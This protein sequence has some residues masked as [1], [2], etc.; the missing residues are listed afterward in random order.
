MREEM[1]DRYRNARPT[2]LEAYIEREPKIQEA[3]KLLNR[4]LS[5][6]KAEEMLGSIL[7]DLQ[8]GSRSHL[9]VVELMEFHRMIEHRLAGSIGAAGAHSAIEDS[10][11][12]SDRE[13]ADLR[14]LFSHL[15]SELKLSQSDGRGQQIISGEGSQFFRDLQKGNEMLNN[16]IAQLRN[17]N[18]VLDEKL[19][20]Q[21]QEIFK[22]R[23][24][25]QRLNM[26]N[27]A[28]KAQLTLEI[29][30]RAIEGDAKES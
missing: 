1:S 21:Y 26:E 9:T 13:S 11:S 4:Y 12:Y 29:G 22:Y 2:G 19:D 10:I 14:A 15:A 7:N 8:L 24:E 18:K 30:S 3:E 5:D 20:R 28:L 27:E 23:L 6:E 16:E 25:A 17:A